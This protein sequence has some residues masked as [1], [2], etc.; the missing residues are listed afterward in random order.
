LDFEISLYDLSFKLKKFK[1]EFPGARLVGGLVDPLLR[2]WL[3]CNGCYAAQKEKFILMVIFK[4][5]FATHGKTIF[6]K[7]N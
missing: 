7:A 5:E 4:Q 3:T 6:N 2:S 1:K